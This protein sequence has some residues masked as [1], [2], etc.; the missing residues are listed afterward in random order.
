M[1][2]GKD[3]FFI[4]FNLK[5]YFEKSKMKNEEFLIYDGFD[6]HWEKQPPFI[7]KIC[8]TIS[9]GLNSQLYTK[10]D[11]VN[12]VLNHYIFSDE[13]FTWAMLKQDSI[14]NIRHTYSNKQVKSDKEF[15][16]KV[17]DRQKSKTVFDKLN[18]NKNDLYTINKNGESELFLLC[19][20]KFVSPLT[21]AI[22]HENDV[23]T[24]DESV[25]SKKMLRFVKI[26]KQIKRNNEV[27]KK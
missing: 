6:G 9:D 5:K 10:K 18:P 11:I 2:T 14:K 21:F 1:N 25:I 27:K 20:N 16:L 13:K 17:V 24:I 22:M 4:V 7:K 15:L 8:G 3:I 26:I 19:I 23:F 12:F